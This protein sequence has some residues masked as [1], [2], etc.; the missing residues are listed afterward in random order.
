MGT[1]SRRDLVRSA[2]LSAAT[3]WGAHGQGVTA[4]TSSPHPLERIGIDIP[5]NAPSSKLNTLIISKP[6]YTRWIMLFGLVL[7]DV[8]GFEVV[9][10]QSDWIASDEKEA[11]AGGLIDYAKY[12]GLRTQDRNTNRTITDV[13]ITPP[14][15]YDGQYYNIRLDGI[16]NVSFSLPMQASDLRLHGTKNVNL[17]HTSISYLSLLADTQSTSCVGAK[18]GDVSVYNDAGGIDLRG[19]LINQ[20]TV[21][22]SKTLTGAILPSATVSQFTMDGA[23]IQNS[24][25]SGTSVRFSGKP[26]S[27]NSNCVLGGNVSGLDQPILNNPDR[28]KNNIFIGVNGVAETLALQQA[29]NVFGV[30]RLITAYNTV[31]SGYRSGYSSFPTPDPF[32]LAKAGVML[33]QNAQLQKDL[34][35]KGLMT[36]NDVTFIAKN[37]PGVIAAISDFY[38]KTQRVALMSK[39]AAPVT[40]AS[41]GHAFLK[42]SGRTQRAGLRNRMGFGSNG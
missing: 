34:M 8:D 35:A 32:T 25:L 40:P 1:S 33:T 24:L 18:L 9:S 23:N 26:A 42:P 37:L 21:S 30:Q 6:V 36:P 39:W 19:A 29:G 3:A 11:A 38:T 5:P 17:D 12:A 10:S 20:I 41:A 4:S 2:L 13:R 14:L 22:P 7:A 15:G 16:R 27:F 28:F 31:I